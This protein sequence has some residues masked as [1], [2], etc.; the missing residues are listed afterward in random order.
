MLFAL[1]APLS[2]N[3]PYDCTRCSGTSECDCDGEGAGD[4][5]SIDGDEGGVFGDGVNDG[6][7]SRGGASFGS[8]RFSVPFGESYSY[9]PFGESLGTNRARIGFSAE[10]FDGQTS[11]V[12][13]NYRY[14]GAIVGRWIVRDPLTELSFGPLFPSVNYSV[15]G[16]LAEFAFDEVT[17]Q[18]GQIL[19]Y[20]TGIF[21]QYNELAFLTN[22][23]YDV[24]LYGLFSV[25]SVTQS[26]EKCLRM[27]CVSARI[28][29]LEMFIEAVGTSDQVEKILEGER[30]LQAS[31]AKLRHVSKPY[32]K[33]KHINVHL[34]K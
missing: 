13:Y 24:D 29:C 12:Y 19:N 7:S 27:P 14:Y 28:K 23:T 11:L 6:D 30:R 31:L 18:S 4:D 32:L 22:R 8:L 3:L 17:L 16:I 2:A 21:L 26:L 9:A 20:F 34:L 5:T 33:L 25:D 15:C 1:C 10:V